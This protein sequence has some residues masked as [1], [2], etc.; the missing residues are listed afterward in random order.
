MEKE[1]D[2]KPRDLGAFARL[3]GLSFASKANGYSQCVLVVSENH[4]NPN[5]VLHGGVVYSMADTGMGGALHSSLAADETC[6]TIEINIVYLKA[7]TTG[8]L[9]CD[10]RLI[11]KSG[12]IGV[13]ECDVENEGQ[14]VA[15]ALGTFSI[16]KRRDA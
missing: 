9:T 15:K 11:H 1:I 5:G 10:T 6:A 12:N 7:V 14:L 3:I 8:V 2:S 4:F 13:L 16:L